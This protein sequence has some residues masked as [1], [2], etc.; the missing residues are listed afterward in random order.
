M[1]TQIKV[2]MGSSCFARGNAK[3]LQ[4]IQEF[5]DKNNLDATV[6]LSGLRCCNNC[7]KGP[8]ISIDDKEYNNLDSGTIIDILE[9]HFK[10]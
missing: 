2:C 4:I 6:E 1:T 3:N 5:I 8:N 9:K 7:S 10:I